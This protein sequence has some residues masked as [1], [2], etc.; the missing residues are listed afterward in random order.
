MTGFDAVCDFRRQPRY[1]VL[2]ESF[3]N[4]GVVSLR[5]RFA[6]EHALALYAD[7]Y[8]GARNTHPV[9]NRRWNTIDVLPKHTESHPCYIGNA[10]LLRV[11]CDE[12]SGD[13]NFITAN[14]EVDLAFLKLCEMF[15]HDDQVVVT[16]L[17]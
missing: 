3:N 6:S 8:S 14:V 4:R 5:V 16:S 15:L 9:G 1:Y 12:L 11:I 17:F 13:R 7:L 2:I 10:N